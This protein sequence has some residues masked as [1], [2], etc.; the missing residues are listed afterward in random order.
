M[1]VSSTKGGE[2]V[3]GAI[4]A[5]H[6]LQKAEFSRILNKQI[7]GSV[8]PTHAAVSTRGLQTGNK[9]SIVSEHL[10]R[11]TISKHNPPVSGLLTKHPIYGNNCRDIHHSKPN[12][13]NPNLKMQ[14]GSVA[15]ITHEDRFVPENRLQE[16]GKNSQGPELLLLGTISKNDPTVSDLMIKHPTYGKDCWNI[17]DSGI[18]RDKAYTMIPSGSRIY[19]NPETLEIVWDRQTGSDNGTQT[20]GNTPKDAE[21]VFLGTIS[22]SDPT[23]S[24]LMI[25]H[26]TYGK[27]CWN[28]IDSGINRDK[29]YTMIP[30]GSRIYLNPETLE[31]VWNGNRGP[32]A[33]TVE[34]NQPGLRAKQMH[35]GES[36]P[37][38][39]GLVKAVKPYLGKP[40]EEIN[41]FELVVQ[42]LEGLG[43]PYYGHGGLGERL[44]KIATG[45]GLSSN[46][47][48]SG[49][50]LIETSGSRI[51][52]KSIP[53]I[54]NSKREARKV[55]QE[56]EPLL[57]EG[58][59]L[60]FST[61]TR[62]HTGIISQR[63][64]T[65][66]YINSGHMD[67]RIEGRASRGV[68]EEFLSTEIRN[69]FRLAA[70]RREPLQITVGRLDEEK[71]RVVLAGKQGA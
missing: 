25:K 3:K 44:V 11:G 5:H 7:A 22:K 65:W 12:C 26:P 9:A 27:D 64:H 57:H 24:D 28:I 43:I 16:E 61:P 68:G 52:S 19:L 23:V 54:R 13:D 36:D 45:K 70:N 42:G 38:S 41:C 40:Y 56:I 10:F 8:K 53:R 66:T 37:F 69:W 32:A 50:G 35:A 62:G 6:G 1:F 59:I 39:T 55:Y 60:S 4:V 15:L 17:I 49:E 20:A 31:I 33:H 30:S 18:N 29:A 67:H 48:L 63:E 2:T 46:H 21:P 58:L 51:Y 34:E 47:Y 14:E 71:L